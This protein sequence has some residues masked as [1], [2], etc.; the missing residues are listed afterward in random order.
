[1]VAGMIDH[2]A[3][4]I[5]TMVLMAAAD[6]DMADSELHV[7]GDMV[8]H[9][10]VFADYDRKRL[11]RDLAD[12][13]ALLAKEDGLQQVLKAIRAAL[14]AKLRETAYAVACDVGAAGGLGREVV[15][16]LE[17]LCDRLGIDRLVA[18]GIARGAEARFSRA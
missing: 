14:P 1:M 9:L 4:L 3:A 11:T 8:N 10:P 17:L 15:R 13:A 18:A 2:H 16:L 6:R 5:Y 12:C 7:I